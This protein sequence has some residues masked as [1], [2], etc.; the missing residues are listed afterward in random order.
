[1]IGTGAKL[2]AIA[3]VAGGKPTF[4]RTYSTATERA[5]L[6]GPHGWLT[7]DSADDSASQ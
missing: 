2:R 3:A 1:V 5:D 4:N 7:S 6:R